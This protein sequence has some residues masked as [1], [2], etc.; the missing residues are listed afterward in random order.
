MSL[1]LYILE[2]KA[3]VNLSNNLYSKKYP[4]FKSKISLQKEL[5]Q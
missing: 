2:W 5:Q 1:I 4:K 3:S